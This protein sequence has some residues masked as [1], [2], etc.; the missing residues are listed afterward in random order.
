MFRVLLASCLALV[1]AAPMAHADPFRIQDLKAELLENG[2]ENVSEAILYGQ[3]MISGRMNRFAF[4][5]GLRDCARMN[6]DDDL[7]CTEAA[8]KSCAVIIPNR[9]R[10][11]FLELTNKYNLSRRMGYMALDDREQ[12]GTLLCVQTNSFF[13]DENILDFDE[14]E[15]WSQTVEDFRS[16]LIDEEVELL[17]MSVL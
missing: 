12:L 15:L 11:D 16:F 7:Y 14:I 4:N 9:S 8:F 6:S 2:I 17:D 3:P 5:V 1:L 10:Q 13:N